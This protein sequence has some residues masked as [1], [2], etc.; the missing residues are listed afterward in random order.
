[1]GFFD[2][3]NSDRKTTLDV[4]GYSK[5]F[6][7]RME[8][9]VCPLN[10]AKV[11]NPKMEAT[12]SDE[13]S[14]YIL[15]EAPG[16][17]EDRKAEQFVGKSGSVL[18]FRIPEE[19]LPVIR[20]NN[21]IRTRPPDNRSPTF[22][23]MECCRPSIIRDIEDT[24]P[25]AIFGFGNVPLHWA[26]GQTGISKWRG[27]RIAV[28]VGSHSCWFYPMLHPAY[29][30][31]SRKFTP[32][33]LDE[34]GSEEEFVFALDLDDAFAEVTIGLPDANV[35]TPDDV[36]H[37]VEM[38]TEAGARSLRIV[39]DFLESLYDEKIVGMD[40]ETNG[41]RPYGEGRKILT[42]ALARSDKALAFPLWHPQARWSSS[43]LKE[44]V[45][46]FRRFLLRA[47]CR[48]VVHHLA[49]EMEWTGFF[50]GEDTLRAGKWGCSMSQAYLLD[51]RRAKSKPG[52]HSL[53]F[54]C[55]QYFGVNVK[56]LAGVD[57]KNLEN[58]SLP[59]VLR[60]NGMDAK[61]H[62][63]LYRAQAVRLKQEG[64]RSVYKHHLRRIPTMVLTQLQGI[65][66]DQKM[67]RKFDREY[68]KRLTKIESSISS[69]KISRKFKKMKGH[70]FRPS[71]NEDV[72]YMMRD[73]LGIHGRRRSGYSVDEKF[74]SEI[75][76]PIAR[77]VLK[78]RKANKVHSTYVVPFREDSPHVYRGS[79]IHPIISTTRTR[80]WRTSSEDPNVQNQPKRDDD[81]KRVRA[82]IKPGGDRRI[83]SFDYGQ[84]QARNI[85]MESLDQA[86]IKAFW[87]RYDIHDDWMRKIL[88]AY[89]KWIPGGF[90]AIKDEKVRDK[91]RHR[92]KNQWVFPSFFG[93]RAETLA[94]YLNIPDTI[95]ID[96]QEEFWDMFPSIK[97]WQ[98]NLVDS[99]YECGYVTGLSGFR[100]RAPISPT[101][102]INAPIQADE[103]LIVCDAMARLSELDPERLQACMEIHD[104][105]I[106]NWPKDQVD[107]NAEE[108][109]REML[110]VPFKWAHVV[111]IVVDMSVGIDWAS[112]EGAGT[113][114]SDEW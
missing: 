72:K 3:H 5:E 94:G 101:E 33:S 68:S 62:G 108:V 71:A 99:Y 19:L 7:H 76:H 44:V 83:V 43:Y 45:K 88:K 26:I 29:I 51:G 35:H 10:T 80:T 84:I 111:P 102:L 2:F 31:R 15:G 61:Y 100:R 41:L 36:F 24:K 16:K 69:M 55:L 110:N 96:L 4:G 58:T 75:D 8:C 92:A 38:V 49:F 86:L 27:R 105:L 47:K 91:Y 59:D 106:F 14:I 70:E 21:C 30:L 85:A 89:P 78:W 90:K 40:Y 50:F 93:A 23:E 12:G 56:E 73:I 57:V 17:V 97:Q 107:R 79:I 11:K 63:L 98:D 82:Q 22:V 28:R 48:K 54:L 81:A 114:S 87:D 104:D 37:Q 77:K 18:R 109:I 46:L 34:Y 65:P 39:G 1:M 13:P 52:P 25:Q 9:R 42:V 95:S 74:L 32:R 67:V 66:V 53:E 112:M 113:Y 64:L 20:F 103:V 6:L 60:Y